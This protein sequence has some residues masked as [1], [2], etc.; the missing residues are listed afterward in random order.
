M[1]RSRIVEDRETGEQ[2][3]ILSDGEAMR[4]ALNHAAETILNWPWPG[5]EN[6]NPGIDDDMTVEAAALAAGRSENCIRLWC[7]HEGIGVFDRM[8]RRYL[9][10]RAKLKAYLMSRHGRLPAGLRD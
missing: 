6:D 2:F 5:V 7:Q 1:S 8:A 9:V 10:S 3:E 4:L